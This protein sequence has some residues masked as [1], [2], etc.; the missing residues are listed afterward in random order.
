MT[1]P[2]VIDERPKSPIEKRI[3][4]RLFEK[5]SLSAKLFQSYCDSQSFRESESFTLISLLCHQCDFIS[6]ATTFTCLSIP[7]SLG[8]KKNL[9]FSSV[10][11]RAIDRSWEPPKKLPYMAIYGHMAIGHMQKNTE[12]LYIIDALA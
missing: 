8:Q 7:T 2:P 9:D 10:L 4:T 3:S 5:F 6:L 12:N 1:T 11:R